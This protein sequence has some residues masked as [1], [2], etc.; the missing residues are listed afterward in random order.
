VL[1]SEKLIVRISLIV[2]VM[3]FL[4]V[5]KNVGTSLAVSIDRDDGVTVATIPH[6]TEEM[7]REAHQ[8]SS[9]TGPEAAH[10]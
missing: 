5:R 3:W 9:P 10:P 4:V 2:M 6:A 1:V 8:S 7:S